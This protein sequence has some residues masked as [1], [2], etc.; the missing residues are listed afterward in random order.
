MYWDRKNFYKN[1]NYSLKQ[2]LYYIF[3]FENPKIAEEHRIICNAVHIARRVFY[4]KTYATYNIPAYYH[5][6]WQY[7]LYSRKELHE[8][9]TNPFWVKM[10]VIYTYYSPEWIAWE[11]YQN[12]II[13][14]IRTRKYLDM[15][16]TVLH[17]I[18]NN[19]LKVGF[20]VR[21]MKHSCPQ[22]E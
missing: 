18:D 13:E 11:K 22:K 1:H 17:I 2:C 19:N 4:Y 12:R 21:R 6:I 20:K 16:R 15:Y 7:F 10:A 9:R 3:L 14:R 8:S 5:E